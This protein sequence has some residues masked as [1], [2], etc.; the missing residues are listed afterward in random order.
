MVE[1]V[2]SETQKH[3]DR[4]ASLSEP[5]SSFLGVRAGNRQWPPQSIIYFKEHKFS[6]AYLYRFLAAL[7]YITYQ[8]P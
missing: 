4:L 8:C 1:R 7:A 6:K 2:V 3:V 5:P